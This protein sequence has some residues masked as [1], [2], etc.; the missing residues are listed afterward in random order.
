MAHEGVAPLVFEE[1]GGGGGLVATIRMDIEVLQIVHI[2]GADLYWDDNVDQ[3]PLLF[4]RALKIY[5]DGSAGVDTVISSKYHNLWGLVS[6]ENVW[7]FIRVTQQSILQ[8]VSTKPYPDIIYNLNMS[9]DNSVPNWNL[10]VK[11]YTRDQSHVRHF[12]LV[13]DTFA[14][15]QDSVAHC[16]TGFFKLY[17]AAVQ[18]E[19]EDKT[20]WP[21]VTV[22]DLLEGLSLRTWG[23]L[24]CKQLRIMATQVQTNAASELEV[25]RQLWD[26]VRTTP[27]KLGSLWV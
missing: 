12:K 19:L 2:L 10:A 8:E 13:W 17:E 27:D 4:S 18:K 5:I 21:Q 23:T 7:R 26:T 11:A 20:K 3:N 22:P 9:C 16:A 14:Q 15:Q 1:P 24:E 25:Q 6:W